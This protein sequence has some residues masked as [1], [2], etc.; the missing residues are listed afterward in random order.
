MR[1]ARISLHHF[2]ILGILVV[3]ALVGCLIAIAATI[4]VINPAL[5]ELEKDPLAVDR[6]LFSCDFS[7][8]A[9]DDP[10]ASP[11]Q[12]GAAHSHDFFANRS[13]SADSTYEGLRAARSTCNRD[14]DT[15]AYWV[16][17]LYQ[18]GRAL[19]PDEA[20]LYYRDRYDPESV[21]AFPPDLRMIAGDSTATSPQSTNVTAWACDKTTI[22]KFQ[23]PPRACPGGGRLILSVFFPN[24]WDGQNLDSPDHKSH[25]AYSKDQSCPSTHPVRTPGIALTV[26]YPTSRGAGLTFSSGSRYTAHADFINAWDQEELVKLVR[27]CINDQTRTSDDQCAPPHDGPRRG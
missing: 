14:E 25:M 15:A 18:N 20:L 24:C 22:D 19:K 1:R 23:E 7:H 9:K 13:T 5:T 2:R 4:W 27:T 16:P 11:G 6:F 12:K 26:K 3:A 8:R 10:I 17:T 21:E